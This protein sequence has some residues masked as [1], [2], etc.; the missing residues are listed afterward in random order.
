MRLLL[1]TWLLLRLQIE[2]KLVCSCTLPY[3][4]LMN[5]N[6]RAPI[7]FRQRLNS[8]LFSF[9]AHVMR[10]ATAIT[11]TLTTGPHTSAAI[12]LLPESTA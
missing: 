7:G 2:S 5:R 11:S 4:L 8:Q 6:G 1:G 12:L 3:L 9:A 10:L